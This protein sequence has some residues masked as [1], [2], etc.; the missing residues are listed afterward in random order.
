MD[1]LGSA[2]FSRAVQ[3]L[4]IKTGQLVC[5][6]IIKVSH[7]CAE[8]WLGACSHEALAFRSLRQG[9]PTRANLAFVS[10]PQNNKDY[11]DQSL[12]EIKLLKYVN[13]M[14]PNDEYAIVRLY[15]FFYYKV[16]R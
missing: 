6:K 1:F 12:D 8:G 11:F 5:L 3:A 4:D 13:T 2:A 7:C 15:D 10:F 14:D 9:Q 16:C